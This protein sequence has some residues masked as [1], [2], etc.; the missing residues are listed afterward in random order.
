LISWLASM[1]VAP[2]VLDRAAPM[3][4]AIAPGR[5]G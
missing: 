2:A 4:S 1:M 5:C 3:T